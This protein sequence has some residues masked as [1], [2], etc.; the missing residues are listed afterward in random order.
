MEAVHPIDGIDVAEIDPAVKRAAN[1]ALYL[2][3]DDETAITTYTMDARNLVDDLLRGGAAGSY[4][5]I[6]GDAFN[7]LSVPY[8]LTTLEFGAKLGELLK[9]EGVYM[10]NIIDIYTPDLGRFLGS[11]VAT[12]MQNFGYVYVFSTSSDGPSEE[13]DTFIVASSMRPLD[14]RDLGDHPGDDPFDGLLFAWAENDVPHGQMETV[15]ERSGGLI[16]TD[17]FAPVDN[18]LAP[19]LSGQ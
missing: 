4:D 6:F 19:I 16:L 18:L 1:R 9:P 13:R 2:P 11:F 12:S 7:D 17:D 3:P 10:I 15:L 14:I 5:F 8:H